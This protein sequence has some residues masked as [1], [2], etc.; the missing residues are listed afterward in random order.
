VKLPLR[1]FTAAG[2]DMFKEFLGAPTPGVMPLKE[3]LLDDDVSEPIPGLLPQVDL[4]TLP[5]AL[6]RYK[7]AKFMTDALGTI[8][9]QSLLLDDAHAGAFLVA[10]R[11]DLFAK[12]D[13][14]GSW[15]LLKTYRY[16]PNLD[17]ASTFYR[18]PVSCIALYQSC[19]KHSRVCLYGPTTEHS[20]AMEQIASRADVACN[21]EF[22]KVIEKL[23]WDSQAN[24]MKRGVL[25]T[26]APFPDGCLRR[27]VGKG[28]FAE[29]YGTTYDFLS[30]SCDQILE[31]LPKEFDVHKPKTR[32]MTP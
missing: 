22:M 5:S 4:S 18:H 30:M 9:N 7:F 21:P 26:K 23:Y 27:L 24:Q 3:R 13:E 6:T 28:S 19:G 15:R 31:L 10:A 29:R 1:R 2:L 32:S 16:I 14:C 8:Q 12:M 17:S 25:A 11:F 20:D